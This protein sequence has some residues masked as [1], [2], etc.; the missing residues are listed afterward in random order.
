[1]T[2][3][4]VSDEPALSLLS[5]Q[6]LNPMKRFELTRLSDE[7][8]TS[9][10]RI[11]KELNVR[12]VIMLVELPYDFKTI[13]N[14][15]GDLRLIVASD[16][17]EC[18]DA[19]TEDDLDAI[20]L[21]PEPEN[22]DGQIEEAFLEAISLDLIKTGEQFAVLY[23]SYDRQHFDTLT[24]VSLTEQLSRLSSRDL[25]RLDT[26]IPLETLR[27][28]VDLAVE[29]GRDGREGKSVGTIF[30]VGNHRKVLL[31][32]K[33]QV[34]DPFRGY[35]RKERFLKLTRVKESVKE[36][37]QIDGAFII[38]S[39]GV[40]EAAGRILETK[41]DGLTVSKGLGARHVAAA[42]ISKSTGAI[43]IA[44]SESTGTV[45]IFQNGVVVLRVEPFH[46]RAL[47]WHQD[48]EGPI[49]GD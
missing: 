46:H 44:V 25:K 48:P 34:F 43:A 40:V 33:E 1:M 3:S 20:Q 35:P 15:L 27:G 12:A 5:P 10:H 47:K 7:L 2:E 23:N 45:R 9:V 39:D 28:V 26:Q 32:S 11:T 36:L 22:R 17:K 13:R 4:L 21:N 30:V 31:K 38:S 41:T 8:I 42:A 16:R 37:A 6:S 29:I 18:L 14:R 24:I 19:A 49:I